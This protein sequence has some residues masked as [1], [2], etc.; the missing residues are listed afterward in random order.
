MERR[1]LNIRQWQCP[2]C[3]ILHERDINAALNILNPSIVG[4]TGSNAWG[5]S[6]RPGLD[7]FSG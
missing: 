1:P 4:A 7:T 6:V 2:V 5:Q 3:G